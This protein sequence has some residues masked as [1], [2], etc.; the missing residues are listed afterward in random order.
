MSQEN[1]EVAK[2]SIDAWNAGDMD[3]WSEFLAPDVSWRV[4]QDWPEQGPFIG[5]ETVL[6]QARRLRDAWDAD[7]AEPVSDFLHVSDHVV[8]RL[9]W[10]GRG[11]GPV[12]NMGMTCVYTV[13]K[14]KIIAFEYFWDHAQAL[15][16][17]GLEE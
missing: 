5:R 17:V 11:H 16:A 10:R 1:V 6:R 7:A 14:D 12:L 9:A 13:R 2:A 15:K 8:V 3:A 4:M